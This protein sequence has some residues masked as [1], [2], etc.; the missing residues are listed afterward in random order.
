MAPLTGTNLYDMTGK[1]LLGY[2]MDQT[3]FYQLLGSSQMERE[4]ERAWVI[5]KSEDATQIANPV[6]NSIANSLYLTPFNLPSDFL[7]FYS[8]KRSIVLVN[9]DGVTFRWYSQIPKERKHEYK[10]DDSKFYVDLKNNQL[11]L[12][13]ILDRTY[14]IHQFY[15]Y[16]SPTVTDITSWVFPAQFHPILAYDVAKKYKDMFDYDVVNAE[17][18]RT[19]E[20]GAK[21]LMEQMEKWDASLQE[22]ELDGVEYP[23][24]NQEASFINKSVGNNYLVY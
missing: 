6:S 5:L 20:A 19:I 3:L 11:F 9:S 8:P 1:L 21:V 10:D 23:M 14:T 2:Q 13:G 18:A 22:S 15:I 24:D 17:Q 12:C 7:N 4:L 16:Q